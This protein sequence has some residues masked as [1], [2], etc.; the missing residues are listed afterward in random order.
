VKL[1]YTV[2]SVGPFEKVED[3][4]RAD[5]TV[6]EAKLQGFVVDLVPIGHDGGTVHLVYYDSFLFA[7]GD[8]V[9]ATFEKASGA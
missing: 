1:K 8:E 7:A 2:H 4:T 9:Q 6:I 5:G 3:V